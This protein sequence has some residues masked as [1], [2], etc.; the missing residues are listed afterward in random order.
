M[1]K[2]ISFVAGGWEY[3]YSDRKTDVLNAVG[4]LA[5]DSQLWQVMISWMPPSMFPIPHIAILVT[6]SNKTCIFT[7]RN[8]IRS[9]KSNPIPHSPQDYSSFVHWFDVRS[10]LAQDGRKYEQGGKGKGKGKKGQHQLKPDPILKVWN[11]T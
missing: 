8:Q 7:L 2:T 6:T 4:R 5:Q 11:I 9:R 1:A 10:V 3:N